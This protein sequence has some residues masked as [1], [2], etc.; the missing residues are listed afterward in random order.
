MGTKPDSFG[1]V[2]G[3]QCT[4]DSR[5][6]GT[7]MSDPLPWP[8]IGDQDYAKGLGNPAIKRPGPSSV[9]YPFEL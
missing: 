6:S 2:T 5:S 3:R 4:N 8:S 9:M 1:L 7:A